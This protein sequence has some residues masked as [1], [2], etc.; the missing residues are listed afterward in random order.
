MEFKDDDSKVCHCALADAF[1][2]ASKNAS[3]GVTTSNGA[4]I[5]QRP[6]PEDTI[7]QA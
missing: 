7:M 5:L 4:A 2:W 3:A 6:H 1:C